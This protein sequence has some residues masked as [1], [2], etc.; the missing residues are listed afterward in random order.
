MIPGIGG[1]AT[2]SGGQGGVDLSGGPATS[3]AEGGEASAG[4]Q[5]FYFAPPDTAQP[6]PNIIRNLSPALLAGAAV[7]GVWLLTRK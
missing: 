5:Q 4:G 1:A 3:G 7:L 6:A 2:L